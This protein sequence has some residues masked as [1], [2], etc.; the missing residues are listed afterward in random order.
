MVERQRNE[1]LEAVRELQNGKQRL[2]PW[3][4]F[5]TV[6]PVIVVVVGATASVG[7][8]MGAI[9]ADLTTLKDFA[10]RGDR[11][12]LSE[13]RALNVRIDKLERWV[14]KAPPSW[15][16][17]EFNSLKGE[18]RQLRRD[19]VKLTVELRSPPTRKYDN[20]D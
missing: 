3:H 19:L 10:S 5:I 20:G 7:I 12:T 8:R 15:F 2:S 4:W 16:Q 1:V 6:V 17:N 13:G 18:V 11:F 14:E 9:E